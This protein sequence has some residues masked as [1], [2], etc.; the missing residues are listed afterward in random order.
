ML[1]RLINSGDRAERQQGASCFF[2]FCMLL[3]L[4]MLSRSINS[5]DCAERQ[6][7]AET[8]M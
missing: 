6:Q 8:I 5:G 4:Y 7:G 3:A 1:C 2:M